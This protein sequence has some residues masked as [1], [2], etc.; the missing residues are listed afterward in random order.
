VKPEEFEKNV[1][2]NYGG[3]SLIIGNFCAIAT[4]FKFIMNG[5]NH[6]L[7]IISTYPFVEI[8]LILTTVTCDILLT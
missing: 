2:Y 1:L 3:D 6:K 7:D 8:W 4:H 5:A